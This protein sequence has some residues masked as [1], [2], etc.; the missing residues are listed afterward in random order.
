MVKCGKCY[1]EMELTNTQM[2]IE[3]TYGTVAVIKAT[4]VHS[5]LKCGWVRYTEEYKSVD[6]T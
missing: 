6:F 4:K 3:R 2:T 1:E 5:C